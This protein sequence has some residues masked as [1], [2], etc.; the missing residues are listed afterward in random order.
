MTS[1]SPKSLRKLAQ[2]WV[3]A[4][5]SV[6]P[7]KADG[8][9]GPAVREWKIWQERLPTESEIKGYFKPGLG[10]GVIGGAVSGNLEMLDFDIPEAPNKYAGHCFFDEWIDQLP[11]ELVE[12]VQTMPTVRTPGGGIHLYYRCD[13]LEGNRKL[14]AV[15][16]PQ[17]V[18]PPRK[19]IIETRGEGGYVLAPG[20]PPECHPT[21]KTYD[22]IAGSFEDVP[23]IT[24]EQRAELFAMARSFD[25]TDLDGKEARRKERQER[26]RSMVEGNR[27]GDD[28]NRRGDW[29][30]LLEP[31]GWTLAFTRRDGAEMWCRPG[32]SK[33]DGISATVRDIE[34]MEL[35][36]AFTSNSDP[37]PSEES[38]TKFT[39]YA[40][41]FHDGDYE[42]AARQLGKDG[43][44][45]PARGGAWISMEIEA[46]RGEEIP[47]GEEPP[48][49]RSTFVGDGE[50]EIGEAPDDIPFS[51]KMSTPPEASIFN[52]VV[53]PLE[54]QVTLDEEKLRKEEYQRAHDEKIERR[55]AMM[56]RG[57][58]ML[59]WQDAGDPPKRRH[60]KKGGKRLIKT[61]ATKPRH[62]SWFILNDKFSSADNVRKLHYQNGE[63]ILWKN[64]KYTR[65]ADANIRAKVASYLTHFA[66]FENKDKETG[67]A[68]YKEFEVRKHRVG[69]M[70]QTIQDM[71]V[72]GEEYLDPCWLCEPEEEE[73]LPDP[74][75]IVCCKNGL[76]DIV[77]KRLLP[78][79]PSFYS[80]T[81]T[82]ITYDPDAPKP[83]TWLR[84]LDTTLD[85]DESR[86][87]LQEWFGYCLVQ[88]TRKQKMLM[89]VG[90]PGSGKGTAVTVL[91]WLIGKGSYCS[92]DFERVGHQFALQVALGKS[93]MIFPDARQS[94]G[95]T[96]G[97]VIGTLLSVS[98]EDDIFIDRKNVPP[99]TQKLNARIMIVSNDVINLSDPSGA[100]NRRM[101]WI[102]FPGFK[103][104]EDTNLKRKLQ[105]ELSGIL[106]WAIEGYHRVMETGRFT[107]PSSADYLRNS[108]QEQASPIKSFIEDM[109]DV[110][111]EYSQ[112]TAEIYKH[113]SIWRK[114]KGYKGAQSESAFGKQLISAD[115]RIRKDRVQV[116]G[117]RKKV[118]VGIS[119]NTEKV[120]DFII[121]SVGEKEWDKAKEEYK[122]QGDADII[123]IFDWASKREKEKQG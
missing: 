68:V 63:F 15:P 40:L 109:C 97:N 16:N 1:S 78:P 59:V 7:I 35:F 33:R 23:T 123:D 87:L 36:H 104:N 29:H 13:G 60:C 2:K 108:F 37:F 21:G 51:R 110:G 95:H 106:N 65:L 55:A 47:W 79:S 41:I 54:A 10:I 38:I 30:E 31:L 24:A 67:K 8:T 114:V 52:E 82:G 22:L 90:K 85:D 116:R 58:G 64:G 39:A 12:I 89:V 34:G 91:Q 9:K 32:K 48:D 25:E 80:F 57:P 92:M 121:D 96:K 66:E 88:D 53:D 115:M 3:K 112:P 46:Q 72:V 100:L 113:W 28:F 77:N 69:E 105:A 81:N 27:P 14:A 74:R 111:S 120:Q 84:F 6:V 101:L 122:R 44:G 98:G 94:F 71:S 62:T 119:L 56:A 45:E 43:Y 26:P 50:I 11:F 103:G 83:E 18:Q 5:V 76:F 70:M 75:E 102:R 86:M 4:G 73:S 42:S 19:T 118:Y 17:G 117:K 49:I 99:V 93:V 61:R 20:C 107:E